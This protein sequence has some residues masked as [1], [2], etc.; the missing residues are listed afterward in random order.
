MTARELTPTQMHLLKAFAYDSR[1]EHAREI[2]EVL[3]QHFQQK[4]EA[5][6]DHLWKEGVIND[7]ILD[8]LMEEDFHE[9]H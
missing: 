1:E 7:E 4:L 6:V 9:K 2:Q 5:E 8:R 3:T